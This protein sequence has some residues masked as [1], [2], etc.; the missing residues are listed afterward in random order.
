MCF[1]ILIINLKSIS[2][3]SW[4]SI[5][6]LRLQLKKVSNLNHDKN[7]NANTVKGRF[8]NIYVWID[9]NV[10]SRDNLS[11]NVWKGIWIC[12]QFYIR[13]GQIV[14]LPYCFQT[15]NVL[16]SAV[17][18]I[19]CTTMAARFTTWNDFWLAIL[20]FKDCLLPLSGRTWGVSVRSN[21]H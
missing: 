13:S 17:L 5:L 21:L 9:E 11:T 14:L 18:T 12:I 3:L 10:Y 20:P 16:Q 6:L 1:S 2:T 4:D 19:S 8:G 7:S 15:Q